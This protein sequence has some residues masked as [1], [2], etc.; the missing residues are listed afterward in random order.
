MTLLK[1]DPGSSPLIQDHGWLCP[2][3]VLSPAGS[4][5]LSSQ[6]YSTSVCSAGKDEGQ[7][8]GKVPTISFSVRFSVTR[9][10]RPCQ[11]SN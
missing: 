6:A 3:Q 7:S 10:P 5:P 11:F 1:H 8:A 4:W 2:S 9:L